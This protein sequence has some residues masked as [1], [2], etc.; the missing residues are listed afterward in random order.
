MQ[1]D[2]NAAL[3]RQRARIRIVHGCL[4]LLVLL[5][6][7]ACGTVG[8]GDVQLPGPL[9]DGLPLQGGHVVSNLGAVCPAEPKK[10]SMRS[11]HQ[12]IR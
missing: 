11:Y 6:A 5:A 12:S 4:S 2:Y 3:P 8:E 9:Y 10:T 1:R 7:K